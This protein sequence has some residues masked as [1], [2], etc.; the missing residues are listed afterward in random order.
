MRRLRLP[1]FRDRR[2]G[3]SGQPAALDALVSSGVVGDQ[4]FLRTLARRSANGA[5]RD[6]GGIRPVLA[7]S[8]T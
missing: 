3:L 4:D 5:C 6:I 2:N 1:S 7:V 8:E